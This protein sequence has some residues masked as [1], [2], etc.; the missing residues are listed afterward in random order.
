MTRNPFWVQERWYGFSLKMNAYAMKTQNFL[1][2]LQERGG[3]HRPARV[4]RP[5][6]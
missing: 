4:A 5:I 6:V 3:N 2:A 1:D